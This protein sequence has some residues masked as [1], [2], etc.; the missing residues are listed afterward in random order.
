MNQKILHISLLLLF[1]RLSLFSQNHFF[2]LSDSNTIK[3]FFDYSGDITIEKYADFYRISRIDK[4]GFFFDGEFTDYDI[5]NK[6]VF[7][8]SFKDGK[9]NGNGQYFYKNGITKESGYFANGIR[10]SVWNFYY[11]NG[12]LDRVIKFNKGN[13]NI[14]SQFNNKGIQVIKDGTGEYKGEFYKA[15]GK[16]ELYKISGNL[17]N[18]KLD[19][20]WKVHGITMEKF[21]NGKFIEGFDVIEYKNPQQIHIQNILG[22]YCHENI[23]LFQ[24][25]YFCN[26]CIKDESWAL[27]SVNGNINS[28]IY[29]NFLF[30]FSKIL[31]SL[32]IPDYEEIIE[33][34]TSAN[35]SISNVNSLGSTQI[36]NNSIIENLLSQ[37]L[38]IPI[39]SKWKNKGYIYLMI[40]KSEG[41][42]YAQ[43]AK[44]ITNDKEANFMLKQLDKNKLLTK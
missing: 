30:K 26:S 14:I 7:T 35:G 39:N 22:Y 5:S 41:K 16:N 2:N 6:K 12:D 8:A 33:F 11:E 21:S 1:S 28:T 15:N 29:K 43:Q 42:I 10:D 18:G 4:N 17:T 19:G 25:N 34:E 38:W 37:D 24:N 3:V 27:Y 36:I 23:D 32:N 13:P 44:V 9:L 20:K 40:V 31:D